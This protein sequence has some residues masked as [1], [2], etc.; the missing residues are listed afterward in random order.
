M[1]RFEERITLKKKSL[2][3][4]EEK[5]I[6]Q[7][8]VQDKPFLLSMGE[9]AM[10]SEVSEPSVVRLYKKLEYQ[11]YQELKV[12]LAQ[13]MADMKPS[14]LEIIDIAKEDTAETIFEKMADQVFQ[15]MA[16]TKEKLSNERVEEAVQAI[17]EANRLYFFGQGL[18]ATMAEDGAHKFMR[19]GGNVLSVKDPHYQAIYASHMTNKDVIVAISHSGETTNIY[20]VLTMAKK[21]GAYLIVITANEHSS[22]A[23]VA[24]NVLLTQAH[25]T[26]RQSD[27]MISRL[28]QLVL[29]DTL[30]TRVAAEAG[31]DGK[32]KIN[33]SRLAVT[34][35]KK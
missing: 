27:A 34:R 22:I 18:S 9:L 13:E 21:H 35:M 25:E 12:A 24:D 28:V 3:A 16:L 19:L 4:T 26:K 23:D 1:L 8:K 10:L 2:T 14:S 29:M 15:A 7:L 17:I 20:E 31:D 6:H 5:I 30:Y 33:Q 32:K 11:S